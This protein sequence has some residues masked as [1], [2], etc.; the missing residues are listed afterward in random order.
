MTQIAYSDRLNAISCVTWFNY[1]SHSKEDRRSNF[2]TVVTYS[3]QSK[4]KVYVQKKKYVPN[5]PAEL[6]QGTIIGI[7][8]Y[9]GMAK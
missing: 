8:W 9:L 1:R 3:S 5:A 7:S 2:L 6:A 4:S